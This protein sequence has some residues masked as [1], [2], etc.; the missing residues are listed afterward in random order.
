MK[1][2]S[3]KFYQIATII[4]SA[5]A[6][7]LIAIPLISSATNKF[8]LLVVPIFTLMGGLAGYRRRNSHVFFYIS[9]AAVGILSSLITLRG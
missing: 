5:I 4:L 2:Q 9:L 1:D 3:Q 6:G 8:T 7:F